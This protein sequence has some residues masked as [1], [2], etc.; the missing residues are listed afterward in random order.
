MIYTLLIGG[1][2]I[3]CVVPNTLSCTDCT[4]P[5]LTDSDDY[6]I[7]FRCVGVDAIAMESGGVWCEDLYCTQNAT[8]FCP[9]R[10]MAPYAKVYRLNGASDHIVCEYTFGREDLI[11][12]TVNLLKLLSLEDLFLRESG[13]LLHA[14]FIRY[15]GCA[16]LFTAPCGTGKSTQASLWET[17]ENAEILNGDRALLRKQGDQWT[18]YGLPIAGSSGIYRNQCA[19]VKAI[20]ALRQAKTNQIRRLGFS[21]ALRYFYPEVT[22]HRW[23]SKFVDTILNLL[24][25][26]MGSVP[27]FL[28]ECRPDQEAVQLLKDT[29]FPRG[30]S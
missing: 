9:M 20:V 27:V 10:G 24:L 11:A 4:L 19:P 14:S 30:D 13:F 29:I 18:A 3:R 8:Y 7:L 1:I 15:D 21:E 6:D 2:R 12:S 22:I 5:F 25:D 23:D 26:L 28:L 16:V 17:H